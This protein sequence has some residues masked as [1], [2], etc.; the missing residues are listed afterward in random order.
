MTKLCLNRRMKGED[1]GRQITQI[2]TEDSLKINTD[3]KPKR[4]SQQ[5]ISSVLDLV[6]VFHEAHSELP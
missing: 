5:S 6:V 1:R 3:N 2:K 4:F